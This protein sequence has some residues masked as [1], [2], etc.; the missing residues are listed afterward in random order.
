MHGCNISTQG[1]S[2]RYYFKWRSQLCLSK[3]Q[4]VAN[5]YYHPIAMGQEFFNDGFWQVVKWPRHPAVLLLPEDMFSLIMHHFCFISLEQCLI[6]QLLIFLFSS[7]SRV[8][9]CL[10]DLFKRQAAHA[11][12]FVLFVAFHESI[13]YSRFVDEC[14][15]GLANVGGRFAIINF[16]TVQYFGVGNEISKFCPIYLGNC[17]YRYFTSDWKKVFCV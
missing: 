10:T 7:C 5:S 6:K 17:D 11:I 13:L 3:K 1:I 16:C 14:G 12:C 8:T 9:R 2:F 4:S 15:S